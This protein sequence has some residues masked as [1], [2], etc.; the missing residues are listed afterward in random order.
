[1]KRFL[2]LGIIVSLLTTTGA[3]FLLTSCQHRVMHQPENGCLNSKKQQKEKICYAPLVEKEMIRGD[4]EAKISDGP[5]VAGQGPTKSRDLGK[6]SEKEPLGAPKSEQDP[7]LSRDRTSEGYDG[8]VDNPFVRTTDAGGDASTFGL[9]VDT[10]SYS[11][12]RRFLNSGQLPPKGAVR[13]EEL[14]NSFDYTYETP[15]SDSQHPFRFTTTL[16][17]CPWKAD[18]QLLRV[19]LKGK[20]VEAAKRPAMNLIFLVDVSGSMNEANKLPLVIQTLKLMVQGLRADDSIGLVTYAG[21]ERVV[22]PSTPGDRRAEILQALDNLSAGGST[23]GAGGIKMAYQEA[24]KGRKDGVVS[25]V[26]LC[27]DGDFNVGI[28]SPDELKDLIQKQAKSGVF[29]NVY[30]FGTGNYQDRTAKALAANGNGVYA[31]MD[32]FAEAKRIVVEGLTGQLITIA[33]DAKCQVFFNPKTVA[34]WRQIGYEYRQLR[35][36][37]FNDDTKDAGDI[38]AGHTVTV[39][40]EIVPAGKNVPV[41]KSDAN[42]FTAPS[43]AAEGDDKTLL[44]LRLR[45]KQPTGDTST[46]LEQ[47]LGTTASEMDKDFHLTAALAGFGMLLRNSPYKGDASWPL[48]QELAQAGR[49]QD[50]SGQRAEFLKLVTL[51]KGLSETR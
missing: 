46:L 22:L 4:V 19:A 48:V 35:R 28:S 2:I 26:I 47:D 30:G 49:G 14:L 40:Y 7:N 15:A 33:K 24:N 39:L 44:R 32:S 23:N 10:A 41:A 6:G 31:Y 27:T 51:A 20:V 37:D 38:G 18:H 25:R 16:V 8:V 34:G 17:R 36:E 42:P 45:Y 5:V 1:M 50:P 13:I 43:V 29:L 9:D 12:V 11:N 3:I 21:S